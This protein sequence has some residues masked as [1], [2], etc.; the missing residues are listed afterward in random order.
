LKLS[1][2]EL[3]LLGRHPKALNDALLQ[4]VQKLQEAPT[5]TG[6][7]LA[8]TVADYIKQAQFVDAQDVEEEDAVA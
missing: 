1:K 6:E 3:T 4:A 7:D 8:C 2:E 5:A